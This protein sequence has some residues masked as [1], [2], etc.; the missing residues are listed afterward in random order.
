MHR[1]FH[2]LLSSVVHVWYVVD[3]VMPFTW[4]LGGVPIIIAVPLAAALFIWPFGRPFDL[5]SAPV[6]RSLTPSSL[7]LVGRLFLFLIASAPSEVGLLAAFSVLI[8]AAN[9]PSPRFVR[10]MVI[11]VIKTASAR[12]DVSV[13]SA[14]GCVLAGLSFRVFVCIAAR[15]VNAASPAAYRL[16]AVSTWEIF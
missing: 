10:S 13:L 5:N 14:G 16:L 1:E 8:G 7:V 11:V 2:R 12:V 4:P 3:V 15:R 6:A 9:N